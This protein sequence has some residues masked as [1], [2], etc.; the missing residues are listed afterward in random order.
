MNCHDYKEDYD[1]MD[2]RLNCLA[3]DPRGS[4]SLGSGGLK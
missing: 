4:S 3:G 2:Y 1:A